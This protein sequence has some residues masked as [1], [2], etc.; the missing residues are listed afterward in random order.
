ML[1]RR[2]HSIID[3]RVKKPTPSKLIT[4]P[5]SQFSSSG[6]GSSGQA[7]TSPARS[8]DRP[9]STDNDKENQG[10]VKNYLEKIIC[11]FFVSF[12]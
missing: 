11:H 9:A 1:M 5:F 2:L 6:S 3:N 7:M 8:G 10:M 12:F 4:R